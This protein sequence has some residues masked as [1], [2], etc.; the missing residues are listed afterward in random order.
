MTTIVGTASISPWKNCLSNFGG[1]F[2]SYSGVDQ[3]NTSGDRL[4]MI[5]IPTWKQEPMSKRNN[6]LFQDSKKTCVFDSSAITPVIDTRKDDYTSLNEPFSNK[7]EETIIPSLKETSACNVISARSNMNQNTQHTEVNDKKEVRSEI[8][9]SHLKHVH[10]NPFFVKLGVDHPHGEVR[11]TG[12]E[13]IISNGVQEEDN[14]SQEEYAPNSGFVDKLRQKF[15]KLNQSSGKSYKGP[16]RFAS[17][18]SLIEVGKSKRD[19]K[20]SDQSS[21]R[22][23]RHD[24]SVSKVGVS[25]ST[26]LRSAPKPPVHPK[27]AGS[28]S[29]PAYDTSKLDQS[30][31]TDFIKGRDDIVIIEHEH[32]PISPVN[33]KSVE[34]IESG[35]VKPIKESAVTDLPKPNTVINFRS[36]FEKRVTHSP[37]LPDFY[38]SKFNLQKSKAP[39]KPPVPRR[40]LSCDI[41]KEVKDESVSNERVDKK[42]TTELK[43]TDSITT[44][45]VESAPSQSVKDLSLLFKQKPERPFESPKSKRRS[46]EKKAIFDSS[47]ITPVRDEMKEDVIVKSI[48]NEKKVSVLKSNVVDR[49]NTPVK[50]PERLNRPRIPPKSPDSEKS[51]PPIKSAAFLET[52]NKT[53]IEVRNVAKD[54][55]TSNSSSSSMFPNRKQI[56]D[57]SNLS[58]TVSS[59]P[60]APPRH[61]QQK[62]TPAKKQD[63]PPQSPTQVSTKNSG[64]KS[65]IHIHVDDQNDFLTKKVSVEEINERNRQKEKEAEKR[66][67]EIEQTK[68]EIKTH[69]VNNKTSEVKVGDSNNAPTRGLPSVIARRLNK[70]ENT[71]NLGR[72]LIV[73]ASKDDSSDEE[74]EHRLVKPSNL[75]PVKLTSN[76]VPNKKDDSKSSDTLNFK[77]VLKSAKNDQ[78]PRTNIDDL[79]GGKRNK[80]PAAVFDSSN[81]A[82]SPK[83][84]T[85]GVPPLNLSDLVNDQPLGHP[86][87]EG[88]I[89]TK[90]QPCRY[91]FEGAGVKLKTTPLMKRRKNKGK[92]QF[93]DDLKLHEYQSEDAALKDYLEQYPHETEEAKKQEEAVVMNL[94][95]SFGDESS[96]DV[97]DP[98]TPR[99]ESS[100]KSNTPLGHTGEFTNYKSK[101]QTEEFQFGMSFSEPEPE[102]KKD[103]T[104]EEEFDPENMDLRP[105]DEDST[106][107][108]TDSSI[109]DMLF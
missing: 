12:D 34:S 75:R 54:V 103:D 9:T 41:T 59:T 91:V 8:E 78:V 48:S 26:K 46:P 109:S 51:A 5:D 84:A 86:Y 99:E 68:V 23:Q 36:I 40:K 58:D 69:T 33:K 38:A 104:K 97:D 62:R 27:V 87:Q 3:T 98:V 72:G 90:I 14:D 47:A 106:I 83:A 16:R 25:P 32:Q 50:K 45:M 52:R 76:N 92:I 60:V 13:K 61:K 85:N 93:H 43:T 42:D 74:V 77:N 31:S 67:S 105:A 108:Y 57:S 10:S 20:S 53:T 39:P 4:E 88:Y 11:E 71:V 89:P 2:D 96:D 65:A 22:P 102:Q 44:E 15:A 64:E 35:T 95:G 70:T 37:K 101:Y 7:S 56:F 21:Q 30:I 24:G 6:H 94:A 100:I 66:L 80:K 82:P 81:I 18:E 73:E 1:D 55:P 79:I 19:I 17:L 49:P 29:S 28:E 63:T 107:N